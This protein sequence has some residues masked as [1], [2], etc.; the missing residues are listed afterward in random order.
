[1]A[2]IWL[3][4]SSQYS[5]EKIKVG[6]WV[7]LQLAVK[8]NSPECS[9]DRLSL[10]G[11]VLWWDGRPILDVVHMCGWESDQSP[12]QLF[13][14]SG[15]TWSISL[16]ENLRRLNE[17]DAECLAA[18]ILG[19]SPLWRMPFIGCL[20]LVPPSTRCVLLPPS[21]QALFILALILSPGNIICICPLL[22][23]KPLC[24]LG[25]PF[26]VFS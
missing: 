8:I 19:T 24:I 3:T 12:F 9:Q 26:S 1:M 22:S 5:M 21:S 11:Y 23:S 18:G 4:I 16:R 17:R 6:Y 2:A 7:P 14:K 10:R 13:G 15:A 25:P 20:I